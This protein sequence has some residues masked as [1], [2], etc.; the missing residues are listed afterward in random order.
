MKL[1]SHII[2]SFAGILVFLTSFLFIQFYSHSNL[3]VVN[4]VRADQS[5][6]F[7]SSAQEN[8][9]S[10]TVTPIVVSPTTTITPV[11]TI[12]KDP[13]TQENTLI[14]VINEYRK[15]SGKTELTVNSE[16]C[17]FASVRAS[18]I[19]TD[20]T[21][22]GFDSRRDSGALPY[23]NWSSV[24]ENIA[25]TSNGDP[26]TMWKNSPLHNANMLADL[27][28]GCVMSNGNYYVFEGLKN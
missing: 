9:V 5:L 20:F 8:L 19:S 11:I 2:G 14:N 18:E 17:S 12:K 3:Q 24:V 27:S 21:H 15:F 28:E 22:S 1:S 26:I 7:S 25:F 13:E 23:S 4:Q 6:S 16:V 10:F